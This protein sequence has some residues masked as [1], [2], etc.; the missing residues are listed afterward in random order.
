[1]DGSDDDTTKCKCSIF[2]NEY[3]I[4]DNQGLLIKLKA[5]YISNSWA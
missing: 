5:W 3:E 2:W 1:M 4:L